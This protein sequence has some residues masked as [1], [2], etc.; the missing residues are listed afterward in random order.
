MVYLISILILFVCAG[1]CRKTLT[2]RSPEY[3]R[4]VTIWV[5]FFVLFLLGALRGPGV[6]VDTPNYMNKFVLIQEYPITEILSSLYCE[7]VEFGY[8]LLNKLVGCFTQEPYA[9][10]VVN[11]AIVCFGMAW[12]I[13]NFT[14]SDFVAIILF[15]CGGM[16]LQSFN[17]TRQMI[18]CVFLLNSWGMLTHG[19]PK[20]AVLLFFA[21]FS[22]H[23]V[24]IIYA[25]VL[26]FYAFRRNR[27]VTGITIGVS[28]VVLMNYQTVINILSKFISVFSNISNPD[29]L[30][31]ANGVWA[32]WTVELTIAAFFLVCYFSKRK[33]FLGFQIPEEL[34][35]ESHLLCEPLFV[36]YYVILTFIGT[37]FNYFH[38]FG[39][40]FLPFAIPLFL[41][42]GKTIKLK[43]EPLY[44]IYTVAMVVCFIGYFWLCSRSGQ[45]RNYHF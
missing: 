26:F 16:L 32:I 5:S 8:A 33:S 19:R 45:Y 35:E 4:R 44:K 31:S 36:V 12:Y 9:I 27:M 14:D 43:S 22:F 39:T 21:A 11:S 40:F 1:I 3:A 7:R 6:G 24:S 10:I 17:I 23:W 29:N 28:F 25:V 13:A 15:A 38:R 30:T 37:R 41:N 2:H 20:T 34:Q 18:A 42:F